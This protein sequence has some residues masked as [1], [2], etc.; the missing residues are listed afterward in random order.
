VVKDFHFGKNIS[1][2]YASF[3]KLV[4]AI[5]KLSPKKHLYLCDSIM[6][7][8][9]YFKYERY[10]KL[11]NLQTMF[12]AGGSKIATSNNNQSQFN[13]IIEIANYIKVLSMNFFK[14]DYKIN[15]VA[16]YEGDLKFNDYSQSEKFALDLNPF[17]VFADSIDKNHK[18]VEVAFKSGINP[19]AMPLFI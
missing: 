6:L 2:D 4:L 19:M 10:D 12:G 9:P 14:S 17:Y 11:D 15:K 5:N 13:L 8:H 3:D 1:E 18:R 16:V 7:K